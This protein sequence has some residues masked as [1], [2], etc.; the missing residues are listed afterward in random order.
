MSIKKKQ[1]FSKEFKTKVVL[2]AYLQVLLEAND[3]QFKEVTAM[4]NSPIIERVLEESGWAQ[5]VRAQERELRER[6]NERWERDRQIWAEK[7]REAEAE[8]E[9]DRQK[10]EAEREA[11]RQRAEA[12]KAE[13]Q[14]KVRLLEQ[15]LKQQAAQNH[16]E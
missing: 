4:M 16:A 11:D 13:L 3:E 10:A 7:L 12:E 14:E 2:E 5:K 15:S 8:R 6:E 1:S 9:A